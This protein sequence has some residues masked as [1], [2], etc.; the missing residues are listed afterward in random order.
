MND[1][2][3]TAILLVAY[4]FELGQG[5]EENK[6]LS[7]RRA[8]KLVLQPYFLYCQF[9]RLINNCYMILTKIFLPPTLSGYLLY[10]STKHWDL[11]W[12]PVRVKL[13]HHVLLISPYLLNF[14]PNKWNRTMRSPNST[15]LYIERRK[16][17]VRLKAT[18]KLYDQCRRETTKGPV[19]CFVFTLKSNQTFHMHQ[20]DWN[21]RWM[22][23]I[24]WANQSK[25]PS[26]MGCWKRK[27][28]TYIVETMSKVMS[29]DYSDATKI[30]SPVYVL[31]NRH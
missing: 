12:N 4:R 23:W 30:N 3:L 28:L 17:N 27:H 6:Y 1:V 14:R 26:A 15:I 16:L 18:A 10:W 7:W 20:Q 9:M 31:I 19:V 29:K 21:K 11:F 22:L 13:V 24:W 8:Y 25:Q 5:T 2:S